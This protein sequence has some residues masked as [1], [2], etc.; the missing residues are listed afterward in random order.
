MAG[1]TRSGQ[2][3]KTGYSSYKAAGRYEKNRE[4]NLKA[5]IKQYPEDE[6]AQ[7]ALKSIKY[8]R[9]KPGAKQ[10]WVTGKIMFAMMDYVGT[11]AKK[12]TGFLGQQTKQTQMK[13]AQY[14]KLTRKTENEMRY[15]SRRS[16]GKS[17]KG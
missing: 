16:E 5:H 13:I 17:K 15:E 7:K 8:R 12:Q 4:R 11:D 6:N 9:K 14:M 3:W 10:G 2:S 1:K